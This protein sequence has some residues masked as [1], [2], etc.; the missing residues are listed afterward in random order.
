MLKETSERE[1]GA[2]NHTRVTHAQ[3]DKEGDYFG[4]LFHGSDPA[5][6]ARTLDPFV[7]RSQAGSFSRAP[8]AS[9]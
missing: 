4:P 6:P 5:Q 3:A 8:V 1:E 2:N 9:V 7:C